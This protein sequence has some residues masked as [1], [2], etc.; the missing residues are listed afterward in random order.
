MPRGVVTG[1]L[2]PWTRDEDELVLENYRKGEVK[3]L[4]ELLDRTPEAV[5]THYRWL[6]HRRCREAEVSQNDLSRP[7][8]NGRRWTPEEQALLED[9]MDLPVAEVAAC[10]DRSIFAT[11][12]RR[13]RTLNGER[14]TYDNAHREQGDPPRRLRSVALPALPTCPRC[15][16]QHNG[17]C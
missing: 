5:R 16:L 13:H 9:T 3:A 7:A 12:Q 2:R 8:T 4:A 1:A 10:L 11:Q 17:D 6:V 15:T 14:F